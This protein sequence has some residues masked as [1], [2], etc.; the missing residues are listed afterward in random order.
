MSIIEFEVEQ[1]SPEWHRARAGRITASKVSDIR[2]KVGGLDARQTLYVAAIRAGM[3]ESEALQA[4]GFKSR[5]TAEAV[6]R[7]LRG[8]KVGDWSD[9]SRRY[10]MRLAVERI[11]GLPLDDDEYS[12]WQAARGHRL[13]PKAREKHEELTGLIVRQVGFIGTADGRFGVSADGLIGL[14]EGSE[15]KAYL[16]P[17]KLHDI[18][19]CNNVQVVRD[20]CQFGMA[21]T[22]RK[23]WHFGLYCPA[24]EQIGLDMTLFVMDRDEDYIEA[25]W[26]DLLE[27]DELV[28]SYRARLLAL[29]RQR[30]ALEAAGDEPPWE[31]LA[32]QPAPPPATPAPAPQPAAKT[33]VAPDALPADLFAF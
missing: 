25:M 27:F 2:A 13:E 16:D 8:E 18:L 6:Q 29:G 21:I 11:N 17:A 15:Y 20:Q 19:L 10:A 33:A 1:G 24:L 5:P 32:F 12:P 26:V 14:E 30:L 3:P 22:G 31:A 9:G 4:A 23:R 28:E 7:A